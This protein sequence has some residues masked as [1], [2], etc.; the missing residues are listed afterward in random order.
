MND[1]PI[2]IGW[3]AC[4][5]IGAVVNLILTAKEHGKITIG[6]LVGCGLFMLFIGPISL[7]FIFFSLL[8]KYDDIVIWRRKS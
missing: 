7:A 3:F 5:F 6:D 1:F 2:L 8:T 4:G